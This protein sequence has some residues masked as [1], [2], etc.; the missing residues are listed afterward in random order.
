M[1]GTGVKRVAL[2]RMQCA[3]C[4]DAIMPSHNFVWWHKL[5]TSYNGLFY[6]LVPVHPKCWKKIIGQERRTWKEILYQKLSVV[7]RAVRQSLLY[8]GS[9]MV[10][11]KK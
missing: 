2:Y 4:R 11:V 1:K 10:K 9:K 3:W 7:V 5:S 6:A 8:I